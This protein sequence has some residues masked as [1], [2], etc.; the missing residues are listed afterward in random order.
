MKFI[1]LLLFTFFGSS[2]DLE[3]SPSDNSA[4]VS[5]EKV[6]FMKKFVAELNKKNQLFVKRHSTNHCFHWFK[7]TSNNFSNPK[8]IALS[9]FSEGPFNFVSNGQDTFICNVANS[10]GGSYKII[11]TSKAEFMISNLIPL[12]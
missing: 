4:I 2:C 11:K 12:E 7:T 10:A 3:N 6:E 5:D 1:Y 8:K 9:R